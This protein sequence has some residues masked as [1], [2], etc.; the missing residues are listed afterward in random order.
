MHTRTENRRESRIRHLARRH[1]Y[2]IRKSRAWKQVPNM[3]N[4]GAYMLI[5]AERN[6]V[7]LGERFNASL[8]DIE[9]FFC[10]V[11]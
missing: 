8:D 9:W 7:V 11:A 6:V 5:Q 4:F 1:G 3:N 10:K 2:A